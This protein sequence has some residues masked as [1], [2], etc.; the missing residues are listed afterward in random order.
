MIFEDGL[1][2][3]QFLR[4]RESLKGDGESLEEL[5]FGEVRVFL[6]NA[7]QKLAHR[8]FVVNKGWLPI[9]A[10]FGCRLSFSRWPA[11]SKPAELR[12]PSHM[13]K[14]DTSLVALPLYRH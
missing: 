8:P 12:V 1:L 6:P 11:A 9:F 3:D 2:Y 13:L 4:V 10:Q 14:V 5:G 7:L